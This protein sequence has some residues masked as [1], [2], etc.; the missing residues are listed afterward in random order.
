MKKTDVKVMGKVYELVAGEGSFCEGCVADSGTEEE[1][2]LCKSLV[3]TACTKNRPCCSYNNPFANKN[4]F[5]IYR[6]KDVESKRPLNPVDSRVLEKPPNLMSLNV[7]H[8]ARTAHILKNCKINLRFRTR[9]NPEVLPS[10]L[11]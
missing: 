5:A 7:P 11:Q 2:W 1:T 9:Q 10:W 4:K 3:D 6:E 8:E